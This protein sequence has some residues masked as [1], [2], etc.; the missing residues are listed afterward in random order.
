VSKAG[1][2]KQHGLRHVLLADPWSKV[3]AMYE[4]RGMFGLPIPL[5]TRRM[6]Y[7]V[8]SHGMIADR[9]HNELSVA[10]HEAVLDRATKL[11]AM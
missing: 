7:V 6:T 4:A 1:F 9:V 8:D 5:G 2:R 11:V 3:A 10:A